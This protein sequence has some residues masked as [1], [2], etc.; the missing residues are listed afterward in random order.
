MSGELL[1]ILLVAILVFGPN[2]LPMLAEHL[3][4][5]YKHFLKFKE[6]LEK[7][8]Q[9]QVNEQQLIQNQLKAK[10]ADKLYSEGSNLE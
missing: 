8:W 4:Q 10:K 1:V 5:L 6:Q 9:Q 3:G 7:F 2:K